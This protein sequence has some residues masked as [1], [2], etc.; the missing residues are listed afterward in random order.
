MGKSASPVSACNSMAPQE[1][2]QQV[3]GLPCRSSPGPSHANTQ[4]AVAA[5]HWQ[6]AGATVC[7]GA[8]MRQLPEQNSSL[9]SLKRMML[10]CRR[11]L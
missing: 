8:V 3:C 9:T 10:G 6:P 5:K 4:P 1:G 11:D 2:K 7:C